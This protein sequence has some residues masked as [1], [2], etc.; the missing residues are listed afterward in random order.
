MER[1]Y[2]KIK[3]Q[4]LSLKDDKNVT[5]Y[6]K[7]K[8]FIARIQNKNGFVILKAYPANT[9][10]LVEAEE[11]GSERVRN[12]DIVNVLKKNGKYYFVENKA[13]MGWI[14]KKHLLRLDRDSK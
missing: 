12:G 3:R 1:V 2:K 5:N 4:Y 13:C 7:G 14:K 11:D 6:L 10:I 8:R 9:N